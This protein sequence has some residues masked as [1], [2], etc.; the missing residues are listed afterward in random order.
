MK[1]AIWFSLALLGGAL[2]GCSSQQQQSASHEVNQDYLI[3]AVTARLAAVDVDALST[4]HVAANNGAI[5]LSG[6]A[7]NASERAKYVQAATSTSG[8]GSVRDDLTIDPHIQGAREDALDAALDVRVSAAIAAQTG[9]NTFHV[10]PSAR[11][12]VVTLSGTASREIDQVIV[13]TVRGVPGVK[14]VVDH[15]SVQS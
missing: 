13:Q 5:T 10:A 15:I 7:R 11:D 14:D 8:V 3:A 1:T 9:V 12:G 2:A 4:V 6:Q